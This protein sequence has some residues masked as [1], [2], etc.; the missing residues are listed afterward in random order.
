GQ[1]TTGITDAN[2]K[3]AFQTN[4]IEGIILQEHTLYY[5]QEVEA[6]PSYR[7]DDTMHWFCFCSYASETCSEC[8]KLL[9]DIKSFRI[10]FEQVG[11]V[12]LANYPAHVD[13]PATGGI[14]TQLYILCG[15]VLTIGPLVYGF[16]LRRRYGRRS[17]Q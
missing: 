13:L 7:L 10:P 9:L 4:I 11:I 12:D 1:I 16:S 5:L 6:P 3:L 14:G 17:K 15:L 2:G 8:D